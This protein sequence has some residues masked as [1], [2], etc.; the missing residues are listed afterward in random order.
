MD[1]YEF[2][3]KLEQIQ[4]LKENEDYQAAAAI[5]DTVD[6]RK[7]KSVSELCNISDIYEKVGKYEESKDILMLAYDRSPLGRMIVYRLAE[8]AIHLGNFEEAKEYYEDF[9]EVAPRDSMKY[10]L[11]YKI[12]KGTRKSLSELIVILERLRDMEYSDEWAYELAYLYHKAGMVQACVQECNDIILWFG[13]GKY[14]QKAMELK[15]IYEPLTPEQMDKFENKKSVENLYEMNKKAG[16]ILSEKNGKNLRS[17]SPERFNTMNLQAELAKE[18][19][20]IMH[21]TEAGAVSSSMNHIKK[22]VNGSNIPELQKTQEI[23]K[24]REEKEAQEMK[25]HEDKLNRN[26]YKGKPT[27]RTQRDYKENVNRLGD[28]NVKNSFNT[29]FREMLAEDTDGQ[30]SL[31]VPEEPMVEKQITGQM[32]IED[33]LAE[34]EKTKKA[35]EEAIAIAEQR[36]LEEAKSKAL[37]QAEDIMGCLTDYIPQIPEEPLE[38]ETEKEIVD[39]ENEVLK[40]ELAAEESISD[41]LE[42]E[43]EALLTVDEEPFQEEVDDQLTEKL[44]LNELQ[45]I[46]SE[47]EQEIEEENKEPE[48]EKSD[49]EELITNQQEDVPQD[50]EENKKIE[51]LFSPKKNDDSNSKNN[52]KEEYKKRKKHKKSSKKVNKT[53]NMA[54]SRERQNELTEE[55]RKIFTYF[56]HVREMEEQICDVLYHVHI[57]RAQDT[58][59]N[60]GNILISGESGMGKTTLATDIVKAI[61]K[62]KNENTG[63]V[64]KVKGTVLNKKDIEATFRKMAGGYLIIEKAGDLE[65]DTLMKMSAAMEKDTDNLLVIMEDDEASL[66]KLLEL[67]NKFTQKFTER[68]Q[69]PILN[70]DELVAF[71]RAYANELAYD[72]DE[73]GTLALYNRIG[74]VEKLDVATTLIEVKE[75]IDEAISNSEK[76]RMKKLADILLSRRYNEEDYVILREK[77]FGDF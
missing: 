30:I 57:F 45:A 5:A 49:Q 40:E 35:A 23:W 42:S 63:K 14:V 75:I 64:G 28:N 36:R 39:E 16:N 27:D 56:A 31:Y 17:M 53:D 33:I 69:I 3:I 74:S 44:P 73:M 9:I 71:G 59:S 46:I 10:V 50:M 51:S 58:T 38:E 61:Q 15:M 68:I 6:W 11:R 34:W 65:A 62:D 48:E 22:L 52:D 25:K 21:A 24:Q 8:N 77:D 32:S 55:Q 19:K 76:G 2:R 4:K 47:S 1:K 41:D 67:N 12:A 29:D 7:A 37:Q 18:M 20:Q 54:G 72:L 66:K 60:S 70:N 26:D 43:V 13:E